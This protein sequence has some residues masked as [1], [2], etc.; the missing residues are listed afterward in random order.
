MPSTAIDDHDYDPVKE[1]LYIAFVQGRSYVYERVPADVYDDF[2]AA[3]SKGTFLNRVIKPRHPY[4][5][6]VKRPPRD[7]VPA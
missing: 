1:E 6:V 4:R 3:P 2:L 7:G 5:E